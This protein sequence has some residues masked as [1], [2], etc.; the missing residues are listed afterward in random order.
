VLGKQPVCLQPPAPIA[1]IAGH[2]QH[3]EVRDDLAEGDNA[4]HWA[5]ACSM[6]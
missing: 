4:R 3:G 1:S 5:P 6:G 2:L